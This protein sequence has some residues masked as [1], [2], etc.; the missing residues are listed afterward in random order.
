MHAQSLIM[1]LHKAS[2]HKN[3][4][5]KTTY[6]NY[7]KLQLLLRRQLFVAGL[8]QNAVAR[9]HTCRCR[10]DSSACNE[11]SQSD[12]RINIFAL[13]ICSYLAGSGRFVDMVTG[14]VSS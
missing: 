3:L 9:L 6:L 7:T 10:L 11:G 12:M 1:L 13:S 8:L 5:N 4:K 14:R 2:M